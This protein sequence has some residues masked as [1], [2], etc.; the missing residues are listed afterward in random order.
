MRI[1]LQAVLLLLLLTIPEILKGCDGCWENERIALLHLKSSLHDDPNNLTPPLMGGGGEKGTK[2]HSDDDCCRWDGVRCHPTTE[3]VTELTLTNTNNE[4]STLP[5]LNASFLLLPFQDLRVLSLFGYHILGCLEINNNAGHQPRGFCNLN[6][7]QVLSLDENDLSGELPRCLSNLT[8]L[9]HLDV[10]RNRFSGDIA[11]SPLPALMA[12]EYIDISHN[13]FRIPMSLLPFFNHSRLRHFVSGYNRE[14]YGDAAAAADQYDS[15]RQPLFQ[16]EQLDLSSPHVDGGYVKFPKFLYYQNSLEAVDVSNVNMRGAVGL[17]GWLMDNN[18]N[19]QDLYLTNCSLSGHLELPK[20]IH[21]NLTSL[22]ISSNDFFPSHLPQDVCTSFPNMLHLSVSDCNFFGKIP[23]QWSKCTS[24]QGLDASKN[25]LSGEIPKWI[26]NVSTLLDLSSND[27]SGGLPPG[28]ISPSMEEVYLSRNRLGGTLYDQDETSRAADDIDYSSY[29]LAFLDLSHNHFTGRIPEWIAR[30]R[31][32]LAYILLNDNQFYGVVPTGF[33]LECSG[34]INLSHNRLSGRLV[35]AIF[36]SN[37]TSSGG[38]SNMIQSPVGDVEF[39]TK[40]HLYTYQG[41]LLLLFSG[42]DLSSNDFTGEIPPQIGHLDYVKV[43]NLSHNKFTGPIP[44]SIA[45]L[46]QIESL[47]L[48][49][50]N[51]SGVIPYQLTKLNS[52]SSFSVAYNNLSG[53]CPPMI[54]QFSTFNESSY[55]GNPFLNC[56]LSPMTSN[57]PLRPTT[58]EDDDDD[59]GE[60][61]FLDMESFYASGLVSYIMALLIITSVLYINSYWRQV[62]FYYVGITVTTCYYFVVDHLPVPTR[63]KFWEPS[64]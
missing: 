31:P 34:L 11:E 19:L 14:S 5:Y 61:G 21:E 52:L 3:K 13:Q 46:S 53:M 36:D 38:P 25:Q 18:T 39:V 10:K 60:G 7:L 6:H 62:W 64:V 1:W 59:D 26:W 58:S 29:S 41:D 43:L 28:F 49:H 33:C 4:N 22:D 50:N 8:S 35:R 47:D 63:Y 44:P 27:F 9:Q 48:S 51:L 23:S 40:T 37:I 42:L 20:I 45:N 30:L 32:Y 2:N 57:P 15:V 12:L 17:P 24:F 55:G 56:T 16:L 54:A